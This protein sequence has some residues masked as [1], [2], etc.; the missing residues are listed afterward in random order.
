MPTER[1]T[2][3]ERFERSVVI[4][5]FSIHRKADIHWSRSLRIDV[6]ISR[7]FD[8]KAR[9][10]KFLNSYLIAQVT[11]E[12]IMEG[13]LSAYL[14]GTYCIANIAQH[15]YDAIVHICLP[16]SYHTHLLDKGI[17]TISQLKEM[18]EKR[19]LTKVEGIGKK[20][21]E[22]IYILHELWAQLPD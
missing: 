9:L 7:R 13:Y 14:V 3:N 16:D 5:P 17:E 1:V 6:E 18:I 4:S 11:N 22:K 12:L 19:N 20:S 15:N 2:V 10:G 8:E 21:A